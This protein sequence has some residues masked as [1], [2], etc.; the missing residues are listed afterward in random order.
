MQT[1]A[2]VLFVLKK[3]SHTSDTTVTYSGGSNSEHKHR[4]IRTF[5]DMMDRVLNGVDSLVTKR[6][7]FSYN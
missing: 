5:I 1:D 2:H 6:Y 7:M 3:Q 4:V